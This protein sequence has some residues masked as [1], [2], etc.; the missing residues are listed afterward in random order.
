MQSQ[1]GVTTTISLTEDVQYT[2][3]M[4]RLEISEQ[5]LVDTGNQPVEQVTI[6]GLTAVHALDIS[7]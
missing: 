4:L 1:A 3:D 6:Q 7:M 2:N 5:G